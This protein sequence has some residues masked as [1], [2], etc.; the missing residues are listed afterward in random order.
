MDVPQFSHSPIEE[1]LGCFQVSAIR[2]SCAHKLSTH[3][4]KDQGVQLL[5]H[6]VG[7]CLVSKETAKLSS[8]VAVPSCTPT[9]NE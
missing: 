3:L 5:D 1:H 9:S 2:F 4:G 6:I 7:V 8:K